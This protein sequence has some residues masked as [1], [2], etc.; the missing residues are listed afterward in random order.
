[1]NMIDRAAIY[2]VSK[3]L[4]RMDQADE[5]NLPPG[6]TVDLSGYTLTIKF[7]PG[8]IVNREAGLKGDGFNYKKAT[9]NLYGYAVWAALIERLKKFNQWGTVQ[10][11]L[12]EA[13]K[14]VRRQQ[15]Q[16]K[17]DE[18]MNETALVKKNPD[19]KEAIEQLKAELP[20]PDRKEDTPRQVK[21][22][23]PTINVVAPNAK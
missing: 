13:M 19:L 11:H 8:T 6:Y 7:A 3:L 15:A 23:P 22:L 5:T 21:G 10:N 2:A 4:D 17:N 18:K 20:I 16:G 12:I 9:Q 14:T 1:M